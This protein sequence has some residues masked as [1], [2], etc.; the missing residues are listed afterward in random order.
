MFVKGNNQSSYFCI[1]LDCSRFLG[2]VMQ[3]EFHLPG[4]L[5]EE[6]RCID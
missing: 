5:L 2:A 3:L 4:A 6:D 1:K